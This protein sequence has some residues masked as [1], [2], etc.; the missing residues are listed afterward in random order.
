MRIVSGIQP[1]GNLHLG[2]YLGA[3][4][5]WVAMQDEWTAKGATCLYFLADLHAIS[6]PHEPAQLGANTREMVA[7]LVSCGIDPDR[8]IL[9][10]QAQ[11]PAHAELQWLLN[12]TARMGWLNR[13]TQWKDKAGKNREGASVAL[14]T[15][16]VLQAADVLLYQA[17]H[18]PVG[19][20][21]KQHLELARD[22]AQKFNNDFA[23]EDAPVFTLPDPIIPPE[24]ARIMSLRDGTAK[25]S[26]S[27]P[28]DMSRINLVDDADTIMQKVKKA[29][30]D[31]EPLPSE[32]AGLEGRAE[33]RNLVGIYATMAGTDVA[34]VLAQFGGQGFGQFKPAL[35]ELLVSKLAPMAERYRTLREDRAALDAILAR[36]AEKARSLAVPTLDAAY[37]ALGLV[38]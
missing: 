6:M 26:K 16:P 14:F 11:V 19:E 27:D 15:Y 30:T 21:Q 32:A 8:S 12:G 13:M 4:R 17:T 1:T 35:G 31:P 22:I 33:A 36:G 2:N 34:G 29:K 3:I 18:V 37:A 5:N 25:M 10:N 20:D 24:A 38:R 23:S 28:S 7:A 9:F